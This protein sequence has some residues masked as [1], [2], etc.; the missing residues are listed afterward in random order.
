MKKI[1]SLFVPVLMASP[2][3]YGQDSIPV[4]LFNLHEE[5]VVK[6]SF[7]KL[8]AV[9]ILFVGYGAASLRAQGLKNINS[10]L[11]EEIYLEGSRRKFHLDN[12]LQYTPGLMVYGLNMVGIK[13]EHNFR[14][15]T[16][17][18]AMSNMIMAATVFG[19]KKLTHEWR[20]DGSD[21]YSFPSGHTANAFAGAEFLRREYKDVS[22]WYGIAG[23]AVAATTGYLRMYNNKHWF[24]DVMAGAG[25][26]ILSTNLAYYLYPSVNKLFIN[27][28]T[29]STTIILPTYQQG[30]VGLSLTHIFN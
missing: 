6:K 21:H 3:V 7:N 24:G 22:P 16:I 30:A 18:F 23:Y 20:P 29:N 9:P 26:G 14:D 5:P 25:V 28:K 10:H 12:Y 27:K 11:N 2:T 13:G 17:I 19:T 1:L 15:R 8:L 4:K